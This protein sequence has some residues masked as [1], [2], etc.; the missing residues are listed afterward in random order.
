MDDSLLPSLQQVPVTPAKRR[1]FETFAVPLTHHTLD[2]RFHL[3]DHH[4]D[5]SAGLVCPS[6][7]VFEQTPQYISRRLSIQLRQ[8]I[9]STSSYVCCN[10][11][12]F[13]CS[14][15]PQNRSLE[16]RID[17]RSYSVNDAVLFGITGIH[18]RFSG[19]MGASPIL[20]YILLYVHP[21]LFPNG[22]DDE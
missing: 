13:G 21:L 9:L 12:V 15:L 2:D 14:N 18:A 6:H 17:Q 20:F 16:S 22:F 19:V 8:L 11:S 7:G 10:A 3:L 5:N 4:P 1:V